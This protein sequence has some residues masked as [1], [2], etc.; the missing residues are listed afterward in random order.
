MF[1]R[2]IRLFITI[3]VQRLGLRKLVGRECSV[4]LFDLKWL[5][6]EL[7]RRPLFGVS[8]LNKEIQWKHQ[9]EGRSDV[10]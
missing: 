3:V 4:F 1:L 8:N 10:K 6:S 9:V 5:H 2:P 7:E